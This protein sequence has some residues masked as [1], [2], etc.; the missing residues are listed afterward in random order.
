MAFH[1]GCL[2][3]LTILTRYLLPTLAS[4][5]IQGACGWPLSLICAF[6]CVCDTHVCKIRTT[7]LLYSNLQSYMHSE[8][9]LPRSYP[10]CIKQL[11]LAT[12]FGHCL[13][14][15]VE[16]FASLSW[17]LFRAA[18][19]GFNLSTELCCFR[20]EIFVC[21]KCDVDESHTA[22]SLHLNDSV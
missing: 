18:Q 4:Y 22:I 15:W 17:N 5:L 2:T 3:V 21:C 12:C 16:F 6:Y 14:L 1:K 13:L 9:S 10:D 20:S 7:Q 11:Q 8:E 19:C